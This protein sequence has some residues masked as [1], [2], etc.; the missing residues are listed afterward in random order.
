MKCEKCKKEHD[1][2]YGSGRFCC[3]FCARSNSTKKD[4]EKFKNAICP[5]CGKKHQIRK[6][7]SSKKTLC[8]ECGGGNPLK[9][10][11]RYMGICIYCGN[12]I[13]K[14]NTLYC[15]H[16]CHKEYD[17]LIYINKWKLGLE[18]AI[19]G[20]KGTSDAIKK[21]LRIKYNNKC[22]KCGWDTKNP[23][24]NKSPLH[25]HHIDGDYTNNDEDNLE[26]LCPNC[27]SLTENFG[28]LNRG[29]TKRIFDSPS[30]RNKG[31]STRKR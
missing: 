23:I 28:S 27:H 25:L 26:L 15:T 13:K 29:K 16:K 19:K 14:K 4:K 1:G 7:A 6:R 2:S 12:K 24:T 11:D 22:Q 30:Q 21:Y 8:V 5:K 31:D 10:D 17:Y 9:Y 20:K 18:K 3:E